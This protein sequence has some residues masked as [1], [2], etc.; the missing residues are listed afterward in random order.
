MPFHFRFWI[1]FL[2]FFFKFY[3]STRRVATPLDI[4]AFNV[5]VFHFIMYYQ[6]F[7]LV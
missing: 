1:C 6:L 7:R 4:N 2:Y 3:Q 5:F